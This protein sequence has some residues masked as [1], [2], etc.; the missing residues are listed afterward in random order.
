MASDREYDREYMENIGR[1]RGAGTSNSQKYG[2][3]LAVIAFLPEG[4][5]ARSRKTAGF[6]RM[7]VIHGKNEG[8]KDRFAWKFIGF[9]FC[10]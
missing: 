10:S 1:I 4:Q 6:G 7:F 5:S 3:Q 9:G 2:R 8:K